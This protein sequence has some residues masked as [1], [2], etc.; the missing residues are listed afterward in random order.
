MVFAATG[1]I[2]ISGIAVV[3]VVIAT[4]QDIVSHQD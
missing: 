2:L 3:A 1:L 4:V